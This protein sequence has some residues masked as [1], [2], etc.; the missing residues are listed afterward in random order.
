MPPKKRAHKALSESDT[1]EHEKVENGGEPKRAR[2]AGEG[3]V[4]AAAA[5]AAAAVSLPATPEC[6]VCME[7][8][9]NVAPADG[10]PSRVPRSLRACPHTLCSDCVLGLL[11]QAARTSTPGLIACH[12]CR[13]EHQLDLGGGAAAAGQPTPEQLLVRI[14]E[15]A[16]L[17]QALGRANALAVPRVLCAYACGAS[18]VVHCAACGNLELCANHNV[19]AHAHLFACELE[20]HD[21]LS[22]AD[23]H[24]AD[25][26]AKRAKVVALQEAARKRRKEDAQE[27]VR[28]QTQALEKIQ[29][30]LGLKSVHIRE[31]RGSLVQVESEEAALRSRLVVDQARLVEAQALADSLNRLG[32]VETGEAPD[33]AA[34][35]ASSRNA[36]VD[37]MHRRIGSILKQ[38]KHSKD[39]WVFAFP[40]DPKLVR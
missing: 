28:Q 32:D 37:E 7:P 22:L 23:K 4:E 12:I 39:A 20:L 35:A 27:E 2:P 24:A 36:E 13:A 21:R 1:D 16:E 40:V 6:S 9:A 18:A 30:V 8:F 34:A 19:A 3:G 11:K 14:P 17:V 15:N 31:L 5:A 25:Q 26:A 10:G 38:L 33:P 29:R